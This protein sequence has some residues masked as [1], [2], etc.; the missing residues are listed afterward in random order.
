MYMYRILIYSWYV[1]I[2]EVID[3]VEVKTKVDVHKYELKLI[4]WVTDTLSIN[5]A[6]RWSEMEIKWHDAPHRGV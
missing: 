6:I 2:F 3:Q 1:H 5:Y 4:Y